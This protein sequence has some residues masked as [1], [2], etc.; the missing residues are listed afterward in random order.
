MS[1][2]CTCYTIG[3]LATSTIDLPEVTSFDIL[4][5]LI[6]IPV[7][8]VIS[9]VVLIIGAVFFIHQKRQR[10]RKIL[11]EKER[12][13]DSFEMDTGS[14]IPAG[15]IAIGAQMISNHGEMRCGCDVMSD[16][17]R[18]HTQGYLY[19]DEGYG[20]ERPWG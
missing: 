2:Q 19:W 4:Q 5:A 13:F 1:V 7:V 18:S 8:A 16:V 20:I 6:V 9:I 15:Q 11:R 14:R 12:G 10:N 3:E 17:G